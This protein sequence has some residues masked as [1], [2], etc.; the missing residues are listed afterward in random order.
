MSIEV[1]SSAALRES[2]HHT[3]VG[4]GLRSCATFV[5]PRRWHARAKRGADRPQSFNTHPSSPRPCT[6]IFPLLD[7]SLSP[8]VATVAT[9]RAA[10]AIIAACAHDRFLA[11]PHNRTT[12]NVR[13]DSPTATRVS[14]LTARGAGENVKQPGWLCGLLEGAAAWMLARIKYAWAGLQEETIVGPALCL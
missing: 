14:A 2:W 7:R 5:C 10:A 12:C 8:G 11:S 13:R 9:P 3:L 6:M 4:I 1:S